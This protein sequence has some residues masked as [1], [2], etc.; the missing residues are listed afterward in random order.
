MKKICVLL[1]VCMVSCQCLANDS[2]YRVCFYNF[3]NLFDTFDDPEKNDDD[4]TPRGIKGWSSKK[5][6]NKLK[7]LYKVIAALNS[8]YP[9]AIIGACEV[10]NKFV[11]NKLLHETPL[12]NF[13][14]SY[15]HYESNDPR[16]IDVAL[17]YRQDIIEFQYHEAIPVIMPGEKESKTRD[18]LY[19]FG[20]I[21]QSADL[22]VFVCHFP[23]R[24]GGVGATVE[25][26]NYVAS[27]LR[28]RVDS[29]LLEDENANIIIMGDLND[30]PDDASIKQ[31]LCGDKLINLMENVSKSND[32]G[33]LKHGALWS[34]FDQIIITENLL[35]GKN[36][37][38]IK[39]K[40]ANIADFDF[41]LTEDE[42]FGGRKLFRTFHGA[43]YTG[44]FSDHLP[45]Y[46]DLKI[47]R[48][49]RKG[50]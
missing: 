48:F 13:D 34:V 14:Y 15:I 6:K 20:R 43:K 32:I 35:L 31:F 42:K 19:A 16:G 40:K 26:R 37:I 17:L 28:E 23:S 10:E 33:T 12:K 1:F 9:A 30:E 38:E 5:F 7:N 27:F 50:R 21:N 3:E 29:I 46:V 4:F 49:N 45:V 11:L 25:K 47:Y 22:H 24:Y 2:I 44:G 36:H 41:L 8:E 39:D 18:I